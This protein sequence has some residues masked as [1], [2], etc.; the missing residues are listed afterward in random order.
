M[1]LMDKFER[2]FSQIAHKVEEGV[3]HAAAEI[4]GIIDPNSRHDSAAEKAED[5]VR[6]AILDSHRF[7]SFAPERDGNFVKWHID[8]HDYFW[9]VSE[10]LNNAKESIFIQDWWL[11]PELYL[12]R[13]PAKGN[14]SDYRLDRLLLRKAQEGVKIY[15]IVYKEVTQTMSMCSAHTKHTFDNLHDNII[16]FRHP[17]HIGSK[18][19][20][21]FWSHHEKVVVVDNHYACIGG[22]DLCFG[23]WDTHNHPLADVHPTN[24]ELTLFPG[25]G[26]NNARI[27]DFKNVW[28]YSSNTLSPLE[29]ARMP[30]HDVHMTLT[31]PVV[32]DIA[33]HFIERYNEIKRRKYDDPKVQVQIDAAKK[34]IEEGK[35]PPRIIPWLEL[36]VPS[37]WHDVPVDI[38]FDPNN[39]NQ[40]EIAK[41][42][43][44]V[45]NFPLTEEQK[46]GRALFLHPH[47][48]MWHD[49]QDR[50]ILHTQRWLGTL[51]GDESEGYPK[52]KT[53]GM[54][55][56]VVRSVSDWSHGVLTE[57]SIQNACAPTL[58]LLTLLRTLTGSIDLKLIAE[59][60]HFIYIGESF[61]QFFI[62]STVKNDPVT[63]QIA[64][65][66]VARILGAARAG[67]NFQVVVVIPEVPGFAGNIKSESAIQTIM[68]AQYR[69]INRGGNSIYEKIRAE[70]YEPS[71]FIRF[72]HLRG[73]DRINAPLSSYID[74]IEEETANTT[75]DGEEPVGKVTF[76]QAQVA[77]AAR[78]IEADTGGQHQQDEDS[79]GNEQKQTKVTLAKRVKEDIVVA[80]EQKTETFDIPSV[81]LAGVQIKTFEKAALNVR[82]DAN[83]A[84]N[85]SQHKF[86][87]GLKD[88][89]DVVR[90]HSGL[91][92]TQSDG[93][94]KHDQPAL[95]KEPWLGTEQE[96]LDAYVTELIYIHT[97]L[98]I[99]DDKRVIMGSANLN[100]RSQKGNGDSEIALVVEDHDMV[101]SR[102]DGEPY[103]AARFATTLRR[104]IFR[105]HL[106]LIPPQDANDDRPTSFMHP[107]P[108]PNEVELGSPED[109]AVADPLKLCSEFGLWRT[110]ARVNREIF[111][112]I[113]R[114][115]P[116]NLV[117]DWKAF[118]AYVPTVKTGHV[119]PG[120]PLP[121]VKEQL[122]RVRGSLVECPMD[123]LIDEPEFVKGFEWDGLNPTL[124][125]Y[126]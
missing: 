50:A 99:V 2:T 107:A 106:G 16:C 85:V 24:F 116:S 64:A 109:D 115:V 57:H 21:E 67:K 84:D 43:E 15:I 70:G 77:L 47:R 1:G 66:L 14:N 49:L 18:D 26:Y 125:I 33:Q 117:R 27:M 83:V 82:G 126:I 29:S 12:R 123:F 97:K 44:Q 55:V 110:T 42:T 8:G 114:P 72:Y 7:K 92:H 59:A 100:D 86:D 35:K 53:P 121:R 118:D 4:S 19:T 41:I 52:R 113:F 93:G 20:V 68:A 108:V 88:I 62:S 80:E 54:H 13:P 91:S 75:V 90:S 122:A 102:M 74:K 124:P 119:V 34:A 71:N 45:R 31:G 96:E 23:R 25:Q 98:M 112:E 81:A 65:A 51:S 101:S 56:Q 3:E 58:P 37:D 32:L 22:L 89:P 6:N 73:Y 105:E 9:A 63:N 11:T 38:Q 120:I 10:L 5:A 17:D 60:K 28:E 95:E 40:A 103:E 30:W 76:L 39:L 48:K 61:N 78:L 94:P 111:T 104:K 79:K 69:S 46:E 36:P 87:L